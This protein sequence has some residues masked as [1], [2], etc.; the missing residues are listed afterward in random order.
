[1]RIVRKAAL[2][3]PAAAALAAPAG[4]GEPGDDGWPKPDRQIG[5]VVARLMTLKD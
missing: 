2:G 1:M 3:D 5:D 4:A